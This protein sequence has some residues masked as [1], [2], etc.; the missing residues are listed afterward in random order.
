[1]TSPNN[2]SS[3]DD[4]NEMTM[5]ETVELPPIEDEISEEPVA[6]VADAVVSEEPTPSQ[7][8]S[9]EDDGM[10]YIDMPSDA[11]RTV[12]DS[13]NRDEGEEI[14]GKVDIHRNPLLA[15][16]ED[17][18]IPVGTPVLLLPTVRVRELTRLLAEADVD[19]DEI[20]DINLDSLTPYQRK[21]IAYLADLSISTDTAYSD[22]AVSRDG[23]HW[24]QGIMHEG[25]RI[26]PG[27]PRVNTNDP[28]LQIRDRLGIGGAFTYPLW[29]TGIWVTLKTP[30]QGSYFN[31]LRD[32]YAKKREMGRMSNGL[33]FSQMNAYTVDDVLD[34]IL[35]HVHQ[36]SY[37][38]SNKEDLLG[39]LDWRDI[40]WLVEAMAHCIYSNG[41]DFQQPCIAT[42]GCDHVASGKINLGQTFWTDTNGFTPM[43]IAHM[44]NS[45]VKRTEEDIRRYK[46][47]FVYK[48]DRTI[49]LNDEV[50]IRIGDTTAERFRNSGAAWINEVTSSVQSLFSKSL[51]LEQRQAHIYN[52][53]TLDTVRQYSHFI[54]AVIMHNGDESDEVVIE[55]ADQVDAL[56]KTIQEDVGLTTVIYDALAK[57]WK[58]SIRTF[59]GIPAYVCPKCE[60]TPTDITGPHTHP[61]LIPLEPIR[62]FFTLLAQHQASRLT[63]EQYR[64]I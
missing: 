39:I 49:R 25:R 23:S 24:T 36:T 34:Y 17:E 27:K 30:S 9:V 41:Y 37:M 44:A 26:A 55:S 52:M 16:G 45:K 6:P 48:C 22:R 21:L 28:I 57:Y 42:E 11:I 58:E 63:K 61:E 12:A 51:T 47:E 62:V 35:D 33:V 46:E 7:A 2:P 18:E 56:I 14:H 8:M 10:E 64:I 4:V 38:V 59:V 32:I 31:L 43:Q 29:H 19:I 60:S 3:T 1:M 13:G 20:S 50:S 15:Y 53:A 40:P 5:D 54:E